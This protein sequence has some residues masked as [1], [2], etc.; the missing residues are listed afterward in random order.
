[1]L[2]APQQSSGLGQLYEDQ[3]DSAMQTPQMIEDIRRSYA[4]LHE[5]Y[6]YG[7]DITDIDRYAARANLATL[8]TGNCG[9]TDWVNQV[10]VSLE[11]EI[12]LRSLVMEMRGHHSELRASQ[13]VHS[14]LESQAPA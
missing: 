12:S 5:M 9:L 6:S 7:P 13:A 4:L 11:D 8:V 14:K 3:Q 1:M 2:P 10:Q